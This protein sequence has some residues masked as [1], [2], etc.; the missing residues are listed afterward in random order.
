MKH[1]RWLQRPPNQHGNSHK[2]YDE[3][4][5]GILF[6]DWRKLNRNWDINMI[7]ISEWRESLGQMK[8]MNSKEQ[9]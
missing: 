7:L 2:L 6:W 3:M 9:D 5:W 1:L 4:K 8:E